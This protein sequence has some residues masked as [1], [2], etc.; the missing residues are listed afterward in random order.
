MAPIAENH[1][2]QGPELGE[3]HVGHPGDVGDQCDQRQEN[4]DR[5]IGTAWLQPAFNHWAASQA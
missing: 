5:Q 3:E 4:G 2:A 1:P